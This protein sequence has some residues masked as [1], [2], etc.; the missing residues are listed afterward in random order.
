MAHLSE[1][2]GAKAEFLAIAEQW[3]ELA[4]EITSDSNF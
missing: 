4:Q 1:S 2:P 3:L